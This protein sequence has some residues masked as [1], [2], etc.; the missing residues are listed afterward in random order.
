[1]E[2][3]KNDRQA[4]SV[5]EKVV[6]GGV[7]QYIL[8]QAVDITKPVLLLLHGGPSMP[9]PGVSAK[10]QDYTIV[11]N[12]SKLI[13]HFVVVFW[14]QRGTGKSYSRH[15]PKESMTVAQFIEDA[16]QLTD[17]LLERFHYEKIFLA[18]HSWGTIIG[19]SLVSQNPH[20]YYSYTGF[21][22]I[23]NWTKNDELSLSWMKQEAMQRGN[24]RALKQ[25]NA[26]GQAPLNQS[27]A[28]WATL[29]KWQRNFNTL[30]YTDEVIKH[31]GMWGIMKSLLRSETY[32]LRDIYNSF[33]SGFQLVYSLSFV[34]ELEQYRFEESVQSIDIPVMFVHGKYDYH[35]HG[36]LVEM[37]HKQLVAKEKKLIW[38]QNSGHSFHPED[39]L[40]NEQ[41]LIEQLS[42]VK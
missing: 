41:Y 19:L 7:D 2:R 27:F 22:Q 1:M 21:S 24:S 30:I 3:Y 36:S 11:T 31:P 40:D 5:V 18:G 29:R 25:L 4:I 15:I 32:S 23:V 20:K 42:Y 28:Q 17:L 33:I 35:V 10:G 34:R 8:I 26:L 38:A 37:F 39:T 9:L 12:T 13:E 6:L 14:D 16:N